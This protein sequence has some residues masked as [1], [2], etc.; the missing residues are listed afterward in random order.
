MRIFGCNWYIGAVPFLWRFNLY[1]CNMIYV[2]SPRTLLQYNQDTK[3]IAAVFW[4]RTQK[5]YWWGDAGVYSYSGLGQ[6]HG[7]WGL[8]KRLSG[9]MFWDVRWQELASQVFLLHQLW[10]LQRG[11]SSRFHHYQHRLGWLT[12]YFGITSLFKKRSSSLTSWRSFS[13]DNQ[14]YG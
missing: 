4:S 10:H 6:M 5:N 14:H 8:H 1:L 7:V 13:P 2:I 9:Q 12:I 3:K 11:L